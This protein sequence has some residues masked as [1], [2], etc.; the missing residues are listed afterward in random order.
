MYLPV[1]L[2]SYLHNVISSKTF[3]FA[4]TLKDLV[5]CNGVCD[6]FTGSKDC[7]TLF[8][9]RIT[10]FVMHRHD[11]KSKRFTTSFETRHFSDDL[12]VR[13]SE[14]IHLTPMTPVLKIND[15]N[16]PWTCPEPDTMKTQNQ[17]MYHIYY[18]LIKNDFRNREIETDVYGNDIDDFDNIVE[19]YL[20]K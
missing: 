12:S 7:F 10:T 9:K 1:P 16:C 15:L 17:N 18:R 11:L 5:Y 8:D 13:I 14:F 2:R 20:Q 19:N 6:V 4:P 3:L